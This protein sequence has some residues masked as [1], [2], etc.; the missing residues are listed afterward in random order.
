MPPTRYDA[1][2]IEIEDDA[3]RR[4]VQRPRMIRDS[5]DQALAAELVEEFNAAGEP[6]QIVRLLLQRAVSA[7]RSERGVV[8][9]I[10]GSEMVVAGCLDAS[11]HLVPVGSRWPLAGEQVTAVALA[12]R[13]P[14]AG[15][16]ASLG[17]DVPDPA[18]RDTYARLTHLL[19]VP[20]TVAGEDIAILCVSRR[21][22]EEYTAEDRAVLDVVAT[23]GATAMRSARLAEKLGAALLEVAAGRADAASVERIKTDILRLASH[24]LRTPLTVLNGYLSLLRAGFFGTLSES[25][26]RVMEILERRTAEMNALVNDMLIAARVD[27]PPTPAELETVDLRTLVRDAADAV[28]PRVSD[29]HVLRVELPDD[30]VPTRVDADRIVLALRNIIDN[31]VKYS[32]SGGDVLC[33]VS[34]ADGWARV[35]VADHGLGISQADREK[36]FTRFGR[37]LTSANSH[38]PGIGLGLYFSREVARRAGGEVALVDADEGGGSIFELTLPVVG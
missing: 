16:F 7:T 9:W 6:P 13:R 32:P 2:A 18:L 33:S 5:P 26:D 23:T 31:A 3:V 17:V 37:V 35:R 38:I 25:V 11:G 27:D 20:V 4:N 29:Q 8:S 19:V 24:E 10:E 14:E 15:I 28:A 12:Q 36:L 34:A 21:R 22:A 1:P 30:A